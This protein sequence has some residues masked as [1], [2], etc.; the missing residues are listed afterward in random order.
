MKESEFDEL[1]RIQQMVTNR[2]SIEERMDRKLKLLELLTGMVSG[3]DNSV[4]VETLRI[5]ADFEGFN[6]EEITRLLEE[7][8]KDGMVREIDG[9]ILLF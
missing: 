2:L 9:K 5:E 4:M 1:Q 7:L 6:N 8:K 3:P